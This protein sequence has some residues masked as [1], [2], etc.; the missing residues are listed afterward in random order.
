MKAS[1][2][3]FL[4]ERQYFFPA[5]QCASTRTIEQGWFK[6]SGPSD[7]INLVKAQIMAF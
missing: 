1:Y 6:Y 2:F 4:Q 3:R 7:N 5:Q